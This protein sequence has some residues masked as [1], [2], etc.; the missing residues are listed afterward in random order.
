MVQYLTNAKGRKTAVV[1]PIR[2]WEAMQAELQK[3]SILGSLRQGYMEMLEME[4]E[5]A[6]IS[7]AAAD[8]IR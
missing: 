3:R 5:G 2:E 7:C 1:L 6:N 4:K 8:I